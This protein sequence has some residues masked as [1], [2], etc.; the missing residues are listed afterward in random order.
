MFPVRLLEYTDWFQ[1]TEGI[2]S[3]YLDT[4]GRTKHTFP[5]QTTG[6]TYQTLLTKVYK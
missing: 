6:Q 3:C 4:P 1:S 5:V 2:L